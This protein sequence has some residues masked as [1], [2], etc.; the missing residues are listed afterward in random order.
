MDHSNKLISIIIPVKN[1]ENY[2][3]EA[4]EGIKKQNLNVEI[5]VVDDGS[6]DNTA[7]L[8][9]KLGCTVLK[10]EKCLGPVI[11]KNNALKIAQGDF[12][13]FHDHDDIMNPNSLAMFY[14]ELETNPQ[15]SA[16]M[17]KVQDFYSPDM[18]EEEQ[19]KT[20]IKKDPYWGLFTGA[21]LMRKSVFDTIGPFN[22]NITAGEIIDWQ[23]R[24]QQFNLQIKK[25]DYVSTQRRIHASNFGK[26][27]AK[28]EFK[29]YTLLLRNKLG[30][31]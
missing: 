20:I 18:P 14:N 4:L 8:A 26:T 22:E 17:A 6:T 25:I 11:A 16:V 1:G 2:L 24:M 31:K 13:L 29:D 15:I 30:R 28:K 21:V 23:S 10:H 12:I 5:I 7:Q 27:Q 3:P 9:E 19:K